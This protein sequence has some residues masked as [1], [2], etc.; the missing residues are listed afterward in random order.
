[1]IFTCNTRY[2]RSL[3]NINPLIACRNITYALFSDNYTVDVDLTQSP[4]LAKTH[5]RR[6]L[7]RMGYPYRPLDSSSHEIRILQWVPSQ[8]GNNNKVDCKLVHISLDED[9]D[10]DALSYTWG[11]PQPSRMIVVDGVEVSVGPNLYGALNQIRHAN[12]PVWVDSIC[13]NQ[14]DQQERTDQVCLMGDIYRKADIVIMWLGE[15]EDD[16]DTALVFLENFQEQLVSPRDMGSLMMSDDDFDDAWIAVGKLFKRP[17]WGR[18]W[19]I[20]EVL[21]AQNPVVCCGAASCSWGF[22]QLILLIIDARATTKLSAT[23]REALLYPSTDLARTLARL[24]D[25]R[26]EGR[27]MSLIDCLAL[28][29]QRK[30]TDP[31]DHVYGMLNLVEAADIVPDYTISADTLYQAVARRIIEQDKDLDVLSVCVNKRVDDM[32]VLTVSHLLMQA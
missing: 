25:Q 27:K 8:D 7:S 29:R 19:I 22:I 17:Y 23:A 4:T 11:A 2:H 21:L 31:R 28:G 14:D 24:Y 18:L 1:M 10:Y 15:D 32:Q 3:T 16:G 26:F 13:I 30:A 20:Q 5:A 12:R 6:H 9:P